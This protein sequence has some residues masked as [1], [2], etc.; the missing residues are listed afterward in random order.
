MLNVLIVGSNRIFSI[1]NFYSRY[2]HEL[3]KKVRVFTAGETFRDYYERGIFNKMLFRTGLSSIYERINSS[4]KE[5]IEQEKPEVIWVFKG[6]EIFP[7]SLEVVRSKNI[8]LVN[9]NPDN[10]FIFSGRGS[11][12]S[13]ITKSI[14][15]YD[16]HFTYN[17]T[18]KNHLEE[19]F[20]SNTSYLPFGF[21][22]PESVYTE[23]QK[24]DEIIKT[25]FLGNPDKERASFINR[26]AD[27]KI[28][29]AVYGHKWKKFIN[30][31]YIEINDPVY[32]DEQWRVLRRY[33][34]QLNF[35]RPHNLDSHNMRSFEV[36]AIGG[37]MV[38]PDT[39]EHRLFFE[40]GKEAFFFNDIDECA[41]II[42]RLLNISVDDSLL[43]RTAA[44][45]RSVQ[46]GYDY[47]SR[48]KYALSEIDNLIG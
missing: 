36:P 11:G 7:S 4:F 24:Q 2:I 17:L 3:G 21:D 35:M 6:M 46:S 16:L 15:L 32:G 28:Q 5:I 18:V 12:N 26:L 34:V 27:R 45:E 19:K 31:P 33:R 13:N 47:K 14:P 20:N 44:R 23:V 38:A 1:E 42:K 25:C 30:H 40:N 22:I 41:D 43:I 9:Y 37:I 48:C 8:K 39:S 10:P 29:I